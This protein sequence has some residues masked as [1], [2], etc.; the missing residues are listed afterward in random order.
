MEIL[1]AGVRCLQRR[2]VHVREAAPAA[3]LALCTEGFPFLPGTPHPPA[4][5]LTEFT[6]DGKAMHCIEVT[7]PWNLSLI[8]HRCLASS[9]KCL[10]WTLGATFKGPE[11]KANIYKCSS[12]VFLGQ[13]Y[14]QPWNTHNIT[15]HRFHHATIQ[16]LLYLTCK[17]RTAFMHA[18]SAEEVLIEETPM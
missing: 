7:W 11:R 10:G 18:C 12:L 4:A 1:H 17:S 14:R 3:V 15:K 9:G 6:G 2:A 5:T 8:P 13:K 16:P